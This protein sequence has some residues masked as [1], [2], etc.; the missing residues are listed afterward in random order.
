[1]PML[2]IMDILSNQDQLFSYQANLPLGSRK[3]DEIYRWIAR[4]LLEGTL[5]SS[6]KH[7]LNE[8]I[9]KINPLHITTGKAMKE[10]SNRYFLLKE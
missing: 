8:N 7:V 9:L 2:E 1:M 3:Q 6:L 4:F 10:V 5:L